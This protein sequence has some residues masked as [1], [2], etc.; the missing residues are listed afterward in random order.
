C[1]VLLALSIPAFAQITYSTSRPK[2]LALTPPQT[3]IAPEY[4]K[5]VQEITGPSAYS[6][7]DAKP[8]LLIKETDNGYARIRFINMLP[9][10][11]SS[12]WDIRTETFTGGP[13]PDRYMAFAFGY[14]DRMIIKEGGN[15]GI[16]LSMP[17]EKLE[18][19]G[20]VKLNGT[21]KYAVA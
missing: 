16:G 1:M 7:T 11:S 4:Y 8:H 3:T 13:I 10:S 17:S 20:H 14:D 2:Q 9:S 18:V 5:G 15:V 6:V 21:L 19:N 12:F